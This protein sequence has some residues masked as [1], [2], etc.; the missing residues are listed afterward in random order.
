[1]EEEASELIQN[2]DSLNFG[3]FVGGPNQITKSRQDIY[4]EIIKKSKL[5][6]HLKQKQNED[7]IELRENLDEQFDSIRGL[8]DFRR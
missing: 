5:A 4:K 6:K 8:L 7:N 2:Q 3:G 1:M